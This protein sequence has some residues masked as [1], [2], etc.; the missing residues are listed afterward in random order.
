M[1]GKHYA[2]G[3]LF[4]ATEIDRTLQL[5][6]TRESQKDFIDQVVETVVKPALPRINRL[7]NQENDARY[8]A[9]ALEYAIVKTLR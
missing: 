9:Y 1:A 6:K 8:L 3:E 5:Y 4:T 7:T 2:I